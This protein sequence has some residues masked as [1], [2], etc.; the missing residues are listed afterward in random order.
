[1]E[2]NKSTLETIGVT[3]IAYVYT[4]LFCSI[5]RVSSVHTENSKKKKHLNNWKKKIVWNV[6][7]L[8]ALNW[9][10]FNHVTKGEG[11]SDY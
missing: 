8:H 11:L 2:T 6:E 9:R 7:T 5:N 4:I 3:Q 1:M 10:S